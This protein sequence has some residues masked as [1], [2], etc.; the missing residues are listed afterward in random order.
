MSTA[1]SAAKPPNDIYKAAPYKSERDRDK[2][3]EIDEWVSKTSL[4][5]VVFNETQWVQLG[6]RAEQKT[7]LLSI[8]GSSPYQL[9]VPTLKKFCI[10]HRISGYKDR[11]KH[12]LCELIVNAVESE[13]LDAAVHPED[14]AR[15]MP[16]ETNSE[17]KM[18]VSPP[19][20]KRGRSDDEEPMQRAAQH[21][22]AA[23]GPEGELGEISE[24][25]LTEI[26]MEDLLTFC[27]KY[28]ITTS[29]YH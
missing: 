5:D 25:A 13:R 24:E 12:V 23:K 11:P 15:P 16:E 20:I 14:L 3:K 8:K 7:R 27:H 18:S 22:E 29:N 10:H 1:G 9:R 6:R 26:M 28:G 19:H 4:D 21:T 2:E 17:E